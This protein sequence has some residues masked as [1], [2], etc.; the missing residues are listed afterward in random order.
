[1]EAGKK[2]LVREAIAEVYIYIYIC[3]YEQMQ[4][5]ENRWVKNEG[6]DMGFIYRDVSNFQSYERKV[7]K[8]L[9][10]TMLSSMWG[11]AMVF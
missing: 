6:M 8:V 10:C 3:M 9:G 11:W 1:M 4:E 5:A 2:E 7:H